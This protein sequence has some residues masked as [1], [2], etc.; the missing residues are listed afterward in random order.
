VLTL[1][2]SAERQTHQCGVLTQ[3]LL[4]AG[5]ALEVVETGVVQLAA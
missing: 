2:S 1:V 5:P 3:Q 4:W